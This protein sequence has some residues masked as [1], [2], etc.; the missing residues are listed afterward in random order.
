MFQFWQ[1]YKLVRY[2]N[3]LYLSVL[4]NVWTVDTI[5]GRIDVIFV[6]MCPYDW[7]NHT[8]TE[9]CFILSSYQ[10]CQSCMYDHCAFMCCHAETHIQ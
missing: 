10:I 1:F 5:N 2:L 8:V 3:V 4:K 9:A 7:L 6:L